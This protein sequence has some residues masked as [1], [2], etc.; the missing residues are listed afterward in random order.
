MSWVETKH[1]K[2]WCHPREPLGQGTLLA[3]GPALSQM[4]WK[5]QLRWCKGRW[6]DA[7]SSVGSGMLWA[8][9]GKLPMRWSNFSGW[10][11]GRRET[12]RW[13]GKGKDGPEAG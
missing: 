8:A 11:E 12:E 9:A 4:S 3:S 1:Y 7:G 5:S 13:N 10:E 6:A 2:S